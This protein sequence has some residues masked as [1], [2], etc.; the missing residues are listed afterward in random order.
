[1]KSIVRGLVVLI[2]LVP[3]VL[4]DTV[5][6]ES[7]SEHFNI[8]IKVDDEIVAALPTR[9]AMTV[10]NEAGTVVFSNLFV[11]SE[12]FL[13]WLMYRSDGELVQ[14]MVLERTN[15]LLEN[16]VDVVFESCK[17]LEFEDLASPEQYPGVSRCFCKIGYINIDMTL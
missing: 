13:G 1:M 15:P 4:A 10:D 11:F 3:S 14:A 9:A 7:Y 17:A 12:E 6:E 5:W 2:V 16:P 8:V